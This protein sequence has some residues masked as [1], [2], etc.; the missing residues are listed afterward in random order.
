MSSDQDH[1]NYK[2][3]KWVLPIL[4]ILLG[5]VSPALSAIV[6]SLS[7]IYCLS[8][9]D[10]ESVLLLFMGLLIMSDSR[11]QNF[12]F[13][14][15]IKN[16]VAPL[17][18]LYSILSFDGISNNKILKG[19]IP[20]FIFAITISIFNVNQFLSF[21]K[22]VSYFLLFASIPVIVLQLELR[23]FKHYFFFVAALLLVGVVFNFIDPNITQIQGRYR[24]MMGNPNGLGI[25]L[26]INFLLYQLVLK[27]KNDLFSVRVK[28]IFLFLFILSLIMCQSRTAL[29]VFAMFY[30]IRKLF[31]QN[32]GF[33]WIMLL[34]F[35]PLYSWFEKKV[36]IWIVQSG[37][38]EYFRVNTLSQGSG[39]TIAWTFAWEQLDKNFFIGNGFAYTEQ[40]YV[41]YY[42]YLS[43]LGHQGNAHNSFLTL[44][45]DTGLIGLSLF[46]VPFFYLFYK[47]N[48][49]NVYAY[50]ILF[51]ITFSA[52]FESWL[53]ASLNPFTIIF[54]FIIVLLNREYRTN[55]I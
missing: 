55:S 9:K 40:L 51:C 15:V 28:Y 7:F 53:A 46:L 22:S 6:W 3:Y 43:H 13:A 10:N 44:W 36:P 4:P 29:V 2:D 14:P 5:L 42:L 35:I 47:A 52:F 37:L 45:L 50:P 24:G 1:K 41:D 19:F 16:I 38:G 54:L 25:F 12:N 32:K 20:F 26:I 34:S 17:F 11:S 23:F 39:R 8:K 33:A 21:Q 49:H 30:V 18:A 27:L 48:R 31:S